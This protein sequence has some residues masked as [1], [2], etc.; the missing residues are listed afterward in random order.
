M[1]RQS[2]TTTKGLLFMLIYEGERRFRLMWDN[3][4]KKPNDYEEQ[5]LES[6]EQKNAE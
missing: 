2:S 3:C 4:L 1:H 5:D 6:K